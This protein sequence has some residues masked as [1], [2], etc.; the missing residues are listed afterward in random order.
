V[1]V[2]GE[3]RLG[4]HPGEE[5]RVA[6]A[7]RLERAA[8]PRQVAALLDQL[9]QIGEMEG[10]AGGAHVHG[11][12][13]GGAVEADTVDDPPEGLGQDADGARHGAHCTVRR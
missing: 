10:G 13:L 6:V 9:A 11:H 2:R 5:G 12:R 1:G 7:E 8:G 3:H 4:H